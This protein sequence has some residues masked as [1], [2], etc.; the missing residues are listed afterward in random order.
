[1]QQQPEQA[2]GRHH[3]HARGDV[4]HVCF[5]H[6]VDDRRHHDVAGGSLDGL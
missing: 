5:D 3:D 1:V 4:D 2:Q 6:R